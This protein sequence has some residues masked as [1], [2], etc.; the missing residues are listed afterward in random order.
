[1]K[2]LLSLLLCAVLLLVSIS[3]LAGNDASIDFQEPDLQFQ[4]SRN[5]IPALRHLHFFKSK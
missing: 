3:A 5:F 4:H 1:M 2:K